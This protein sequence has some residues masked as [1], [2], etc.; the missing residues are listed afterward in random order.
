MSIKFNEVTW[1]SKLGAVL[2][3][4]GFVPVFSF[5][6]GT[7]Y[8]VYSDVY[9]VVE[10]NVRPPRVEEVKKDIKLDFRCDANKQFS[11]TYYQVDNSPGPGS[12]YI[13]ETST[14]V[15]IDF[16]KDVVEYLT[17]NSYTSRFSTYISQDKNTLLEVRDEKAVVRKNSIVTYNNC[18]R[19]E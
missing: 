4:F 13:P 11:L 15:V 19:A 1:Y 2:L 9:T 3:L 18:L 6:V 17:S 7:Q 14:T 16:G 8:H 5:Y 12:I 10:T